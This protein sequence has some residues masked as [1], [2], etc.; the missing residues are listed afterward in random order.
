MGGGG[1]DIVG[2]IGGIDDYQLPDARGYTSLARYLTG[3]T[4]ERL[5]Q[6]R[7]EVLGA[8]AA[9]FRALAEVVDQV[10]AVGDVVVLGSAEAL[11]AANDEGLGLAMTKVM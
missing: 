4:D 6:E 1:G 5:Q 8:T 3:D 2:A 7:D 10:A 11:A 9:D